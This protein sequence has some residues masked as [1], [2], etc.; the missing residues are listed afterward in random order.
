[1]S[2]EYLHID[3]G[4]LNAFGTVH[5]LNPTTATFNFSV[6]PTTDLVRGAIA[7]KF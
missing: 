5:S 4:T 2:V 6:N 1:L 7:Y 3:L